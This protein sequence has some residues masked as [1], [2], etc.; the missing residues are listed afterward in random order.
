MKK[1]PMYFLLFLLVTS[2]CKPSYIKQGIKE[3]DSLSVRVFD[4]QS[5]LN[6]MDT[7]AIKMKYDLYMESIAKM[8]TIEDTSFSKEE[9]HAMTQYGHVRKALR[10]FIQQMST[11]REEISY[12]ASQLEN[13]KHDLEKKYISRE[14]YENYIQKEREAVDVFLQRFDMYYFGTLSQVTAFDTLYPVIQQVIEN[15]DNIDE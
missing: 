10:N 8:K 5:R 3:I 11:F 2:A 9:W 6:E 13:L 4:A 1:L 7:A 15:H 14:E 12:S